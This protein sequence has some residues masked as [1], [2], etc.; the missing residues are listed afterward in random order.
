[1]T[2]RKA[3]ILYICLGTT[4]LLGLISLATH[5]VI[6]S[7]FE[8]LE[9][10]QAVR[11]IE[12][13]R[14][15]VN[16][17]IRSLDEIMVDWAVWDDS[18]RFMRGQGKDF[19]ESNLND[20]TLNS[21]RLAA[22]VFLDTKGGVKLARGFNPVQGVPAKLPEGLMQQLV[23]GSP[24]L[25]ARNI[26]DRV[27]G[28]VLLPQGPMF[29]ASCPITKSD[30]LGPPVGTLV[31]LRPLTPDLATGIA[32]R[33][34]LPLTLERA[35]APLPA[36]IVP[37]AKGQ[38]GGMLAG[39]IAGDLYC[40]TLVLPDLWGYPALRLILR[41]TR[42]IVTKGDRAMDLAHAWTILG[43]LA[44]F[45]VLLFF[46]E[47]R[48]LRRLAT[49][50]AQVEAIG[51]DAGDADSQDR[52]QLPAPLGRVDVP[53][54]DELALL[55]QRINGALAELERSRH[56]LTEQCRLTQEQ[57]SYLQQLLD[58]IQAGVILVD[59]ETHLI[60]EVNAFAAQSA[61]RKRDDIVGRLCHGFICPNAEG[62]CP[63]TDLGQS[64]DQ[65]VRRLIRADGSEL[66]VLKSVST[67]ERSGK[68]LLL[69]TFIDVGELQQAQ[70]ALRQSEETYR[71]VFM[72]TGTATMLIEADT[73]ITLANQEFEKLSG[74]SRE[75][76]EGKRRWTE[77]FAPRDVAWMLQHHV[78]RRQSPELAPRNYEAH[79][80]THRGEERIVVLTVGMI[81]GTAISVASIEDITERKQAEE[82]LRHQ[83]F[84]DSLTGLPNRQLLHDRLDRAM[85]SARREGEQIAVFLLDMDRFK[86]V[87]DSLGH[88]A[89]DRLLKLVAG[90]LEQAVRRSDTVARLGGDEFVLVVDGPG[91]QD[92][93][94]EVAEHLLESFAQPFELDG[95]SLHVRLSLGIALFPVHGE[96]PEELLKNADLAM[97]QA[98]EGGRNT[99]AFFTKELN[100]Q[101]LRRLAVEAG[102]RRAL[103]TG[104][105]EVFYQPKVSEPGGRI[106]G[107]EALVRWRRE[108]GT[109][110][111]PA[112]FISV[113]EDTGLI[114]PLSRHV[115]T[116]AGRQVMEWRKS[117]HKDFTVAV[118]L[119]P[120]QFLNAGLENRIRAVLEQNGTPPEAME[121]EITENLLVDNRPETIATLAAL[122]D[123]GSTVVLDDFGKEY[124]SLSYI[125][126]LPVQGIKID[127]SFIDGLPEDEDDAS[128]VRSV[129]SLAQGLELRVVA[130]GVETRQQRDFLLSLGCTEFQGYLFSRPISTLDM[131]ELLAQ[132]N[133]FADL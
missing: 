76:I 50:N 45:A 79:F 102:L 74:Y 77:F 82:Q 13:A 107:A 69:E 59:P 47:R 120:R 44:S 95:M 7:T 81:P 72:N 31:M 25:R 61:G 85:E 105:I 29:A 104:G 40:A 33:V 5:L 70:E 46:L 66:P 53:G 12:R 30:G 4:A 60:R 43:T 41:D 3:T 19:V 2:L 71:A 110:V 100:D 109:L 39:P 118:N 96:T 36:D 1:M 27:N 91:G 51:A 42:E 62:K 21:L 125:K 84:H 6:D 14:N 122:S 52:C 123:M 87:N 16:Q 117:G 38:T 8:G 28:L 130:E 75:E 103:A 17:E 101:V 63:V 114:I 128:I 119:S 89:G 97:Y 83:A 10:D 115:I 58:S 57:E 133:P 37:L 55:A 35:D 92:M 106:T 111:P 93:A 94:R 88:S 24:L 11:N 18:E 23:V 54:S 32:E 15:A 124:S 73:T 90:R 99:Y 65:A 67:I 48:V 64:G 22:I 98:K 127:R 116:T 112:E 113:A 49:L 108:D 80:I 131:T 68:P 34:R 86:D 9:R 121:F 132:A 129:L 56:N 126:K 20:R 78:K 26:E